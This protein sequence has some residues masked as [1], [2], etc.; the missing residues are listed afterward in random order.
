M[1]SHL[2]TIAL[3]LRIS[4][5]FLTHAQKTIEDMEKKLDQIKASYLQSCEYYLIDKGDEKAQ[6]S[7]EFFKFFTQFIDQ[8]VKSMPKEEKKRTAAT[9]GA[10]RKVG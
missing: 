10:G 2:T 8:V 1:V 5:D 3:R 4:K 7:Q 9:G 6:S